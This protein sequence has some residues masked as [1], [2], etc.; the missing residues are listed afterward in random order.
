MRRIIWI[1]LC[2]MYLRI[3]AINVRGL[4]DHGKFEKLKE[5]CKRANVLMIQETN[6]RD[7]VMSEFKNN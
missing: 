3:A 7:E 2:I 5:C 6:W 4:L 1:V